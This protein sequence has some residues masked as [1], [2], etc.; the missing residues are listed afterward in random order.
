MGLVFFAWAIQTRFRW[1]QRVIYWAQG[2]IALVIVMIPSYG[3]LRALKVV[4]RGWLSAP[5]DALVRNSLMAVW[6]IL[7]YLGAAGLCVVLVEKLFR[8]RTG[9]LV[10][11]SLTFC[12]E[13][14]SSPHFSLRRAT[15]VVELHL[16]E[17]YNYAKYWPLRLKPTELVPF[18][19]LDAY[20]GG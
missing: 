15:L 6:F 1:L 19:F 18:V 4:T 12:P 7:V 17:F 3:V 20:K 13:D 10:V 9:D 11:A 5:E 14:I 8:Y 2:P 16:G